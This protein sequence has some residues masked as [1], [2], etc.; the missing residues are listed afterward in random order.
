MNLHEALESFSDWSPIR[1][2]YVQILDEGMGMIFLSDK[3]IAV[4]DDVLN[5]LANATPD[6]SASYETLYFFENVVDIHL[7]DVL[8]KGKDPS[9]GFTDTLPFEKLAAMQVELPENGHVPL[10]YFIATLITSI[11]Y[12]E[13]NNKEIAKRAKDVEDN[14]SQGIPFDQVMRD[15]DLD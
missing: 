6:V 9:E 1:E 14:P 13:Q 7:S 11:L 15:L 5:R 4:I 12:Y 2:A 10:S 3:L 8:V